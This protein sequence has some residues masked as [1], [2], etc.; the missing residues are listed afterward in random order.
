MKKQTFL[1]LVISIVVIILVT[2]ISIYFNF[3]YHYSGKEYINE[4]DETQEF[5][6]NNI[7]TIN[8]NKDE[9]FVILTLSDIQLCDLED[10]FHFN[11]IKKEIKY[12]V[13]ETK[14]NL[15]VL[16]GDQTWSNEN[17]FSLKRLIK[18]LDSFKIPYAPIFGNHDYGNEYNSAVASNNYCSE[19]YEKAKYS[20]FDR[21]PSNIDTLG[22]YFINIIE[23]GKIFKTLCFLDSGYLDTITTK[24]INWFRYNMDGIKVSN[25]NISPETLI[26]MHKPL[27]QVRKAY[28]NYLTDGNNNLNSV[29]VHYSL[30]GSSENYFYSACLDYNVT[31][32]L[33]A[34]QHGNNFTLIYNGIRFTSTLKT[35]ELG[36]YYQDEEINLN[37][38]TYI[39][40]NNNTTISNIYVDNSYH[41]NDKYN[42]YYD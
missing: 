5:N 9:D 10:F 2:F 7:K 31:D 28:N 37:G 22:N 39:T 35:G 3:L 1:Y 17:L 26:F 34:H 11:V 12:L 36:G 29:H 27:P 6:I 18:L 23:D 13:K 38:A 30:S 42:V 21:G 4:F 14:P 25:N 32:I 19:L 24:Q 16:M 40:L 8:K 15:I 33:S 20:L 41:I